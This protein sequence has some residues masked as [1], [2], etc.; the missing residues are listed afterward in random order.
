MCVKFN[1]QLLHPITQVMCH[2]NHHVL[3]SFR[4]VD[5]DAHVSKKAKKE[6]VGESHLLS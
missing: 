3:A 6:A 5:L 2:T 4:I 1:F